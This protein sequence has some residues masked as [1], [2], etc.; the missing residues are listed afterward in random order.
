LQRDLQLFQITVL[1]TMNDIQYDSAGVLGK[2]GV[3]PDQI[4]DFLAL[5]GDSSDNIPGV[6]G[7]GPKTAIGLLQDHGTLDG[8]IAAAVEGKIS[9]KKGQL[10]VEYQKDARL[11]AELATLKTDLPLA[12]N[13]DELRYTFHITDACAQF[14]EDLDFHSLVT[15]WAAFRE[16]G[17][18]ASS[19]T[20][21]TPATATKS[22]TTGS[23]VCPS[24]RVARSGAI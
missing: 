22:S 24:F 16:G 1:D 9:G 10:I 8:V 17:A 12:L 2:Y 20:V 14:L 6:T 11:S 19:G 3:R 23:P 21:E 4:R 7:V 5:V 15:K 13:E 18:G